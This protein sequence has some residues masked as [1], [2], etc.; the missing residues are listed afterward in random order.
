MSM[1]FSVDWVSLYGMNY[2]IHSFN[3]ETVIL[4]GFSHERGKWDS[5]LYSLPEY[6]QLSIGTWIQFV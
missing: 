3:S 1:G 4:T 2:I 5:R 6:M